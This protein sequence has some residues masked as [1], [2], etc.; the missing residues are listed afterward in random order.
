MVESGFGYS[1]LPE[2]ALRE[3]NRFFHTLRIPGK[4]LFRQQALAAPATALPRALTDS[5][6]AFL[7]R[8]IGDKE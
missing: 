3:T 1:I 6:A 8:T 7:K 2:Y 4:K 5:V